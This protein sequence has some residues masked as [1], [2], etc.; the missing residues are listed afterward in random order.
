[1]KHTPRD[2]DPDAVNDAVPTDEDTPIT[3]DVLDNDSDPDGNDLTAVV[4][5][6][7]TN[8]TASRH[9]RRACR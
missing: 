2:A 1:M 4:V 3:I 5:D 8:G 6:D 9:D 7:P